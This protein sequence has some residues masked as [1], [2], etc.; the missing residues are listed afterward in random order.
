MEKNEELDALPQRTTFYEGLFFL[1]GNDGELD[2]LLSTIKYV[3]L[4]FISF[5]CSLHFSVRVSN[6][7]GD[8]LFSGF[9]YV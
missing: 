2:A 3:M 4:V 1:R 7:V 8:L 6:S 9:G 5:V